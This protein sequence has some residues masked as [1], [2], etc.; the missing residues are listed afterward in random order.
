MNT[1]I[2]IQTFKKAL[3]FEGLN[4]D[5][6]EAEWM[7]ANMIFKGYMKGYLSHEKMFLVLGKDNPFP[8]VSQVVQSWRISY[9]TIW[10]KS[11][12]IF[13]FFSLFTY[14]N[15][16]LYSIL[17]LRKDADKAKILTS[18]FDLSSFGYFQRGR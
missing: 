10:I 3:D 15:M 17:V 5:L 8:P 12:F 13:L 9:I 2:S 6:E 1:R 16:K 7:L 4:V 14:F 18:Q 11:A